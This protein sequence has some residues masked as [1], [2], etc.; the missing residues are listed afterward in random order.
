MFSDRNYM[1]NYQDDA[2]AGRKTLLLLIIINAVCFLFIRPDSAQTFGLYQQ[3]ALSSV[4]IRDMMLWQP[5]TYMFLHAN[6]T[7]I[8]FNMWGLYIFGGLVAEELGRRRFLFLYLS[9]GF[10]GGL[11]WLAAN[12]ETPYPVVGAS[13]ALFGVMLAM[14]MLNPNREY[15]LLLFPTPIKC[16]TLIIVYALIEIFSEFS[17]T[18]GNIAHLAHL[19]G[20]VSAYFFIRV[21]VPHLIAWDPL[22]FLTPTR[23]SAAPPP[24][25]KVHSATGKTFDP[26]NLD[27]HNYRKDVPVSRQEIDRLLDKI[28]TQGINSLTPDETAALKRAREQLKRQ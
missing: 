15:L 6:F 24:G 4:G 27:A 1:K 25:W 23:S 7:H 20:F 17:G 11:L 28:A 21:A 8:L 10:S 3:L 26:K 22:S 5:L 13:G 12:W 14:A 9:S 16:K 2:A 19:G 18:Q